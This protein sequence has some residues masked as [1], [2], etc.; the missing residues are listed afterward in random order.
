MHRP[1][2][3]RLGRGGACQRLC[4]LEYPG[5]GTTCRRLRTCPLQNG[6]YE[7]VVGRR[8]SWALREHNANCLKDG[9]GSLYCMWPHLR[10]MN[11]RPDMVLATHGG[12]WVNKSGTV[13]YLPF[14]GVVVWMVLMCGIRHLTTQ[15]GWI[16]ERCLR[17][18]VISDLCVISLLSVDLAWRLQFVHHKYN[19]YGRRIQDV[20]LF[21]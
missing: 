17:L 1:T 5:R 3:G 2:G 7:K 21:W 4:G 10:F 15:T 12:L 13:V 6:M 16:V 14:R 19:S 18:C 20:R 8:G 9:W 11:L